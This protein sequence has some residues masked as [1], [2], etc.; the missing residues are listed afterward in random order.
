MALPVRTLYV[1]MTTSVLAFTALYF[2]FVVPLTLGFFN[3]QTA[4]V[5]QLKVPNQIGELSIEP[6]VE[7]DYWRSPLHFRPAM[8]Q[9]HGITLPRIGIS[10]RVAGAFSGWRLGIGDPF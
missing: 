1:L 3:F 6:G 5:A 7:L 4:D 10:Y 9:I 2:N 8:W